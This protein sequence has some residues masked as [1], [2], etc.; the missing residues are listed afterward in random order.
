[1]GIKSWVE[2][3]E[4][5]GNAPVFSFMWGRRRGGSREAGAE[6]EEPRYVNDGGG[7]LRCLRL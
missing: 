1:M 6:E 3:K 4:G 7:V 5:G 2:E